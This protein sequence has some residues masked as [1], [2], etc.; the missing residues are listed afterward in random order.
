VQ[1]GPGQIYRLSTV[2]RFLAESIRHATALVDHGHGPAAIPPLGPHSGAATISMATVLRVLDD[3]GHDVGGLVWASECDARIYAFT[4]LLV[5]AY[6]GLGLGTLEQA[7]NGAGLVLAA[8]ILKG[9]KTAQPVARQSAFVSSVRTPLIHVPWHPF[10]F[11][12]AQ[13][14]Q[15]QALCHLPND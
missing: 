1:N 15:D 3:P 9:T 13:T 11:C 4:L 14:V 12:R 2:A 6:V 10:R 5:T 7:A 8:S